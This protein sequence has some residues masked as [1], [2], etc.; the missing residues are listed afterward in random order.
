MEIDADTHGPIST[1][2][3]GTHRVARVPHDSSH[4]PPRHNRSGRRISPAT[5]VFAASDR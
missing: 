2:H 5:L 4:E 1:Y 3:G